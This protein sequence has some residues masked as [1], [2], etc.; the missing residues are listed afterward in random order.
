METCAM[1][2]RKTKRLPLWQSWGR[3][4]GRP[5]YVPKSQTFCVADAPANG[6]LLPTLSPPPKTRQKATFHCPVQSQYPHTTLHTN[7]QLSCTITISPTQPL[8]K[9]STF[10]YKHNMSTYPSQKKFYSPVKVR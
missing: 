5:S 3:W 10:L 8:Q 6:F 9:S 7:V 2:K 1:G 4:G